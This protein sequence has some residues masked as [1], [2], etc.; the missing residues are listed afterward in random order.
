[1][2]YFYSIHVWVFCLHITWVQDAH[3][4]QKKGIRFP[5][6]GLWTVVSLQ[7]VL[8]TESRSFARAA[9]A[10]KHGATS[11]TL[12]MLISYFSSSANAIQLTNTPQASL[13]SFSM[14]VIHTLSGL[15][16]CSYHILNIITL[17]LRDGRREPP[18][19]CLLWELIVKLA[20]FSKV[21]E[22]EPRGF[23]HAGQEFYQ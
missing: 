17:M 10:F 9:S 8:R 16:D 14:T 5:G 13:S 20:L 4:G 7:W 2:I 1:M 19:C 11:P 18:A 3:R 23:I 21:Q 12:Q 15:G 6:T 22:V